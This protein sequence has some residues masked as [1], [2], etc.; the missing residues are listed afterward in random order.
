MTKFT[1]KSCKCELCGRRTNLNIVTP[2]HNSVRVCNL[3][4][5]EYGGPRKFALSYDIGNVV[6]TR[7]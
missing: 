3:C 6:V 4:L 1:Q 7:R 5:I 2:D